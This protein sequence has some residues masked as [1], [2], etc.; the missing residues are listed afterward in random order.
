MT[1]HVVHNILTYWK[2]VYIF[3]I[4]EWNHLKLCMCIQTTK[5]KNI[6]QVLWSPLII[7]IPSQ[8]NL[9]C[10]DLPR[11]LA[12]RRIWL[13]MSYGEYTR[14]AK[15]CSRWN[16]TRNKEIEALISSKRRS[17]EAYLKYSHYQE[18]GP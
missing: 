3:K 2:M 12:L 16:F 7:S 17:T 11:N 15:N 10:P 1:S 18:Q 13:A 9:V 5:L 14:K 4:I 8:F 6:V